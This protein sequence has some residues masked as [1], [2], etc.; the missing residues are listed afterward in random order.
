MSYIMYNIYDKINMTL[1]AQI[2]ERIENNNLTAF[3]CYDFLDLSSYSS[4]NKVLERLEDKN[5]LKRVIRGIYYYPR[6]N[7]VLK[8]YNEISI[9][10]TAIALSREFGWKIIPSGISALNLLG[11][12]TQVPSTYSYISSGPYKTYD[13]DGNKL[14]FKH[15][16]KTN[17]FNYSYIT[18]LLIIALDEKGEKKITSK[19]I[20]HLKKIIS[21]KNKKLIIKETT[22]LHGWKKD[23]INKIC[24]EIN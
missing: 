2:F 18:S 14:I 24:S 19:D 22:Q 15:T 16:N 10:D 20:S 9:A 7:E 5:I 21:N 12:S 6:Y 11:L 17:L 8:A 3:S 23:I 13:I 1:Q 4:I